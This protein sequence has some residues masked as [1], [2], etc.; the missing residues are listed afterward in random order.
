MV[1]LLVPQTGYLSEIYG[2]LGP[3]SGPVNEKFGTASEAARSR[4]Q[5]V[6][7]DGSGKAPVEDAAA[8][9]MGL[10]PGLELE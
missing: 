7:R 10:D 8:V 4:S 5:E 3:G 1:F 2:I 6:S 9:L